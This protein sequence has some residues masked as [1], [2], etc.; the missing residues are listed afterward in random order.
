MIY[1][2]WSIGLKNLEVLLDNVSN[3]NIRRTLFNTKTQSLKHFNDNIYQYT[4][5]FSI[6]S[7]NNKQ[8]VFGGIPSIAHH[9]HTGAGQQ[10]VIAGA[11]VLPIPSTISSYYDQGNMDISFD[12]Y[13]VRTITV[14]TVQH[15]IISSSSSSSNRDYSIYCTERGFF[16]ND[17]FFGYMDTDIMFNHDLSDDSK[18]CLIELNESIQ[19]LSEKI[20]KWCI[21]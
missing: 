11:P 19:H 5:L 20:K 1:K 6:G 3:D 16:V 15:S 10:P 13:G 21:E 9:S 8:I 18:I 12:I 2:E 17:E 4:K 14:G 7:G